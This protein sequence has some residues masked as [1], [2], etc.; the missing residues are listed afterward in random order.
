M[1]VPAHMAI[2]N[3][4]V[5]PILC[6]LLAFGMRRAPFTRGLCVGLVCAIKPTFAPLLPFVALA[7]GPYALLGG[8]IGA[9]V[10]LFPPSWLMEYLLY[11]GDITS[12][13]FPRQ[14]LI[15]YLGTPAALTITTLLSLY[16]ALFHRGKES[17]YVILIAI[18]TI[19][20][21]LWWH[22]YLPLIIPIAYALGRW[23]AWADREAEEPSQEMAM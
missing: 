8:A 16:F 1:F 3:G 6:A 15:Y 21:A 4:Q 2:H 18:T 5:T 11:A 23:G 20:T 9:S 12:R 7:F 17:T 10:A 19:G 13:E 14:T 22:S